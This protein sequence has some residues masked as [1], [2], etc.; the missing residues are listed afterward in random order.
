MDMLRIPLSLLILLVALPTS[1]PAAGSAKTARVFDPSE[2]PP[3]G[4]KVAFLGDQGMGAISESVLKLVKSEGAHLLVHLGDFDY[5]NNPQGWEDQTNRILGADFPQIAVVGNHDLPSWYG[6][7]G[8]AKLV[9]DRLKRMGVEVDGVA[10]E[11]CSFR[12]QG[13]FF[14]ITSPGLIGTGHAQFIRDRLAAD[15]T[16]WRISAWHVNQRLMQVGGKPDEAGWGVY[17]E[18]RRGGAIIATAHEHSY[19]RTHLL[20]NMIT[21]EVASTGDS[22]ELRKGRTFAFVSG[23]GGGEVRAQ[24]ITGSWWAK[25]YTATQGATAGA[26]FATFNVDGNP[27]KARFEFKAING[28]VPDRFDVYSDL[29]RPIKPG[30][31]LKPD[32]APDRSRLEL[33]PKELGI[34][35]GGRLLLLDSHGRTIADINPLRGQ[36]SLPLPR[37]GLLFLRIETT[38]GIQIRKFVILP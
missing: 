11:R 38:A 7:K 35:I 26:M 36:V 29:D 22:L 6:P 5:Q 14:V 12:Y 17:E 1:V 15:S 10:G 25:A 23:L 3:P 33:D 19:S 30:I 28:A 27:L 8:Y 4:F 37:S 20:N 2:I 13:I 16:P 9:A 34:P 31:T 24:Y 18:S 21:R 32:P